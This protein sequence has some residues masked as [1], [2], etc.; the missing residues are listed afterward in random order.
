MNTITRATLAALTGYSI[1]GFS[2]LFSKVALEHAEPFTL[3]SIRF[4]LAFLV[5]NLLLFTGKLRISLRGKPV[6]KLLLLGLIQPVAYFI[7][8]SYGI[9]MTSTSFSG[10]MI[11]AAPV[12][13]LVFDAVFLKER[14]TALQAAC[15][16]ASVVGVALTTTGGMGTFSL[17][18]FLFLVGAMV[19][20]AVFAVFSR[21]IAGEFSAVER[22]YVMFALGSA[23]F[24]AIA[25]FR[26]RGNLSAL[27]APLALPSFWV[28]VLYLAVASSVCAFLLINYA[29]TSLSAGRTMIFSN[30]TT[31]ISILAG[32]FIMGDDFSPVQLLG[33]AVIT[34][35]V[36][37]VSKPAPAAK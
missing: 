35:S 5:L 20:T 10:V 33:M 12:V 29:L 30:F 19:S 36:F 25:L 18:G 1:F 16:A 17:A 21:S 15:T 6:G 7:C 37:G 31:V 8:E 32:I 24:T 23:V 2:F 26:N 22:T 14:Y 3:L 27:T 34:L 28:S 13:G 4:L 9:A 11:G